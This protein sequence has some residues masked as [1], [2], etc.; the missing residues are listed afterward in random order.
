[1]ESQAMVVSIAQVAEK[2]LL[3]EIK[4]SKVPLLQER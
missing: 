3:F 4:L 1:M 2:I